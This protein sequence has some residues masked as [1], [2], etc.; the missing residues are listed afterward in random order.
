MRSALCFL[1]VSL[2][3]VRVA[4]QDEQEAAIAEAFVDGLTTQAPQRFTFRPEVLKKFRLVL[5]RIFNFDELF[6]LPDQLRV[7]NPGRFLAFTRQQ[8]GGGGGNDGQQQ[9]P[10]RAA[11]RAMLAETAE[12]PD[13]RRPDDA[14]QRR[15]EYERP[16]S[17]F[18]W[19]DNRVQQPQQQFWSPYQPQ[20]QSTLYNPYQYYQQQQ[21]SPYGPRSALE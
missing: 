11:E 1:I 12:V 7:S 6:A 13:Q 14:E 19:A 10:Q 20:Q 8:T 5:K 4:A 15:Q 17:T 3:I 9:N 2:T 18:G 16:Q 21:Q